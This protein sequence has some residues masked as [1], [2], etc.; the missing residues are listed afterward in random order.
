MSAHQDLT[1][2]TETESPH[3]FGLRSAGRRLRNLLL[4]SGG[5]DSAPDGPR[6]AAWMRDERGSLGEDVIPRFPLVRHGYDCV[7]VDGY[8]AELERDV[9]ELD[10][11]LVA[12]RAR[13]GAPDEV[14][15]EL[16]RIGEQTSSVLIAAHEQQ[17]A[18]LAAAREE[19]HGC[20]EQARARASTITAEAEAQ[21]RELEASGEAAQRQRDRLLEDARAVSTELAALV[22]AAQER[23]PA[24][25][26]GD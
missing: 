6:L 26:P 10:Q 12:M 3:R 19:A 18:I 21:A 14:A 2:G 4:G 11:E 5:G 20:V 23:I 17:E 22:D 8:V 24:H 1:P 15:S 16:R 25:A 9:A 7:A 13:L